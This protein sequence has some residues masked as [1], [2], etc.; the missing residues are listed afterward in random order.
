MCKAM[1]APLGEAGQGGRQRRE[2][3]PGVCLLSFIPLV[4]FAGAMCARRGAEYRCPRA[5]GS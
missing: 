4:D 5:A 3:L 1:A 2:G